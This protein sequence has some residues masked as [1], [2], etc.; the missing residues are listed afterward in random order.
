[1]EIQLWMDSQL[2]TQ[3]RGTDGKRRECL[4]ASFFSYFPILTPPDIGIT[5]AEKKKLCTTFLFNEVKTFYPRS[6]SH[7]SIAKERKASSENRISHMSNEKKKGHFSANSI[8]GPFWGEGFLLVLDAH[9]VLIIFLR[10]VPSIVA[11]T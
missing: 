4:P 9:R 11:C 1:M 8:F 10:A 7:L 3:S 5:S 2:S 6:A